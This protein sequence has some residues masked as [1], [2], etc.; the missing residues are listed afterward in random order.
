MHHQTATRTVE[1]LDLNNPEKVSEYEAFVSGHKYGTFFQSLNWKDLKSNWKHEIF[2]A[3]NTEKIVCGSALVLIQSLPIPLLRKTMLYVPRG[4]VC[5]YQDSET[6]DALLESI[7]KLK[8]KYNACMLRADPC[9][10]VGETELMDTFLKRGF[11]HKEN[12]LDYTTAQIRHNY[13]IELGGRS[14]D[15]LLASFHQK[16][17]YKIRVA[18]RKGV[19]CKI[20]GV[21]KLPDFYK[22]LKVTGARDG[23]TIRSIEYYQK[24]MECF[25]DKCRLYI[26]YHG[27]EA[28]SGAITVQYAGKTCYIYG[29]SSNENR[30]L[31]PNY[32]MQW[33]MIKWA[34]EGGSHIYDFM[35]IPFY[36]DENHSNY[37]VYK[38]KKGFNG[39]VCSF[40]GEFDYLFSPL[41][42]RLLRW[43]M[44]HLR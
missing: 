29:A 43:Y 26:C 18:A 2:V 1:V 10:E 14:A 25:G 28:L 9:I 16:W 19:E 37:G 30:N 39:R 35:G 11:V 31:M 41:L 44:T 38:F 8:K 4:P 20:C 23:F 34:V 5:D 22:I 13:I 6:F 33:E 42:G 40:V 36:Y 15:E 27:D 3:R 32:L 21:D 7:F 12:P 24:M 17:R